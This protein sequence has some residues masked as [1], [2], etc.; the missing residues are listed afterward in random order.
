LVGSPSKPS[1]LN[2]N[3]H[4][5]SPSTHRTGEVPIDPELLAMDVNTPSVAVA[6]LPLPLGANG[7]G[8]G[9]VGPGSDADAEGSDADAEG[10][11]VDEAMDYD[12]WPVMQMSR[13]SRSLGF[14]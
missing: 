6:D 5:I 3:G 14:R 8:G 1:V 13:V 4:Y 7:N 9:Y 11:A 10:E 2:A 12:G